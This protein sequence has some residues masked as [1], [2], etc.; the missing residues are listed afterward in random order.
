MGL[1]RS[2]QGALLCE[3]VLQGG[4]QTVVSLSLRAAWRISG[5]S[6]ALHVTEPPGSLQ[7]CGVQ[8]RCVLQISWDASGCGVRCPECCGSFEMAQDVVSSGKQSG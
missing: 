6:V 4:V 8:L 1:Q 3:A 5:G 2:S 7:D